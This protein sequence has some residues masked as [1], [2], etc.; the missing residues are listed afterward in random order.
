M[1]QTVPSAPI[2]TCS[3]LTRHLNPTGA[4]EVVVVNRPSSIDTPDRTVCTHLNKAQ[5]TRHICPG[6]AAGIVL[7]DIAVADRHPTRRL[8]AHGYLGQIRRTGKLLKGLRLGVE[9]I[10][11]F[12]RARV[13]DPEVDAHFHSPDCAVRTD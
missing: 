8:R 4:L 9:V 11:R 13:P 12:R 5:L 7:I 3:Q 2:E 10:D 6:A 1:P